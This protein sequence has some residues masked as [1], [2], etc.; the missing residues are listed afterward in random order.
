[1]P[2]WRRPEVT[3]LAV[4]LH[5]LGD[6]TRHAGHADI[7]REGPDGRTGTGSGRPQSIDAAARAAH[8]DVI[9]AAARAAASRA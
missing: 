6:T 5:V 1:M 8:R 3:L 4:M 9:E 2:W 7:L